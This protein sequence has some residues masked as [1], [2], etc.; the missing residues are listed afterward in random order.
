MSHPAVL[1]VEDDPNDIMLMRYAWTRVGVEN[2][3]RIV[4]DGDEA[5]RY[6]S[7]EGTYADRVDHPIPSL[8]LMDLKLPKVS[9]LD[10]LKWI[11]AQP[12]LHGLR[13]IV[14]SSSKRPPDIGAAHALR[15]DA[16]LV[17]SHTFD[18]WVEM[19]KHLR[20]SWLT[21]A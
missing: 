6:L 7:G 4:P 12:A 21:N 18:E 10:V 16:Y 5:L 13:V 17:K 15:I 19:V 3:L 2:P 8:I 9:G 1:Y 20:E 11:R 14:L